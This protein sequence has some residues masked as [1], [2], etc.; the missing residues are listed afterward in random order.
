M[1]RSET[2]AFRGTL[3]IRIHMISTMILKI[4]PLLY[5][6]IGKPVEVAIASTCHYHCCRK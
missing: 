1:G 2:F 5:R 6:G 4:L 3:A